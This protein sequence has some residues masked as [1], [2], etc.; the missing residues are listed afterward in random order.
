M[1][2]SPGL[3]AARRRRTSGAWNLPRRIAAACWGATADYLLYAIQG[4]A[5]AAAPP[6]PA[7]PPSLARRALP[8][9]PPLEYP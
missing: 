2:P 9:S 4:D 3:T 5:P 1:R 7:A 6:D 8:P